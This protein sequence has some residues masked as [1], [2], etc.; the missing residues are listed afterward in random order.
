MFQVRSCKAAETL[1]NKLFADGFVHQSADFAFD[2]HRVLEVRFLAEEECHNTHC[3]SYY[4]GTGTTLLKAIRDAI[5][6]GKS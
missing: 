4:E 5:S 3:H 6:S 1:M 2:K